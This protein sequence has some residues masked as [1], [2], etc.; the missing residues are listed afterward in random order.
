MARSFS[1]FRRFSRILSVVLFDRNAEK[2][3]ALLD[4]KRLGAFLFVL[5]R[6]QRISRSSDKE[7]SNVYLSHIFFKIGIS[8]V[9]EV[10]PVLVATFG[11]FFTTIAFMFDGLKN[12]KILTTEFLEKNRSFKT[13][14]KSIAKIYLSNAIE[15]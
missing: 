3:K 5:E 9:L 13:V 10:L 15:Q 2:L 7:I 12:E 8:K 11:N 4:I 1:P 14:G 6:N